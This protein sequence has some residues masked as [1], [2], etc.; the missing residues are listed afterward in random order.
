MIG[1]ACL[2]LPELGTARSSLLL[3]LLLIGQQK[4]Y[5]LPDLELQKDNLTF[6]DVSD[7]IELIHF[8]LGL[9]WAVILGYSVVWSI[10]FFFF[11]IINYESDFF[12]PFGSSF[13]KI[14]NFE[15]KH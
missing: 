3:L 9:G 10:I 11:P 8:S 6:L 12:Q 2:A 15:V 1:L 4:L 5:T 7:Q 13:C 14:K